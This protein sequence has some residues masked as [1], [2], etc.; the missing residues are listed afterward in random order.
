MNTTV[1]T[2]L[3]TVVAFLL[4]A[5]VSYGVTTYV[6]AP[7]NGGDV[8]PVATP[9]AGGKLNIDPSTPKT[10]ECPINGQMYTS[11]EQKIW[12]T[13]RPLVTMIEN[14]VDARPQSGLNSADV[15]YEAVAEGGVTRFAAVFYCEVAHA[16]TLLAPVR[17]ARTHFIEEASEY[18]RP[19]YQHVGGANCDGYSA[20]SCPLDKRVRALDQLATFG[21]ALQNDLDARSVGLPIFKRDFSRLGP[22]KELATEHTM[23]TTTESVFKYMKEK[24]NWSNTDP[25]GVEWSQGFTP[26]TFKDDAKQ[27]DRGTVG[28]VSFGFWESYHDYDAKWTYDAASNSYKRETAGQP[29]LDLNDKSQLTAKVVVVQL[30]KESDS[31]DALKHVYI[32][33][34]GASGKALIF[35]DGKVTEATWAKKDRESR[36]TYT[37]AKGKKIA[38]NRG[39][40][41]VELVPKDNKVT[42]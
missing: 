4:S 3:F 31:V 17:S 36:T 21:W 37:D 9:P 39:K 35:Q 22:D 30:V 8:T 15:L 41:V 27:G 26:W 18:N 40:I 11:A 7:N 2:I 42:Y 24:R 29:H 6:F 13:H 12:Q 16:D 14:S 25:K 19:I 33:L 20:A 38:F 28:S 32:D 10:S 1:K 34:E 5:G 23:T